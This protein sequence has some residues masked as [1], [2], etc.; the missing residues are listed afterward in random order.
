M[1][2]HSRRKWIG[3][4]IIVFFFV[5][6]DSGRLYAATQHK[7]P[8]DHGIPEE[9]KEGVYLYVD[10]DRNRLYVILNDTIVYH[11]AVATGKN[12]RL[13]PQG[14]FHIVTKVK[15]PWYLPT[16]I[17]GG[18]PSNPLGTRWMGLDVEGTNGYKYGIHGTRD[19]D[20]IGK[21]VSQGCVRMKNEDVEWLYRHIPLGTEVIIQ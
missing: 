9:G 8:F 18:D 11:F 2:K 16:N 15:N 21:H 5:L 19:P 6:G 12:S 14:Y 13:T 10:R 20:S 17:R 4:L 3:A 1:F 7:L